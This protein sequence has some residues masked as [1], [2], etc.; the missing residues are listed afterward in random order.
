MIDFK[1]QDTNLI[2]YFDCSKMI[3]QFSHIFLIAIC[4]FSKWYN[5]QGIIFWIPKN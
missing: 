5:L 4:S 1:H 2:L 3:K